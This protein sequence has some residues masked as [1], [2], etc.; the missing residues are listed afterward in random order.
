MD[1]KEC[2]TVDATLCLFTAQNWAYTPHSIAA[3]VNEHT[4]CHVD[5]EQVKAYIRQQNF[6]IVR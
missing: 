5:E 3:W 1:E 2:K 6:R 4:D